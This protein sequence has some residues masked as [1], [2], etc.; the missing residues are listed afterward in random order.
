MLPFDRSNGTVTRICRMTVPAGGFALPWYG[1]STSQLSPCGVSPMLAVVSCHPGRLEG[2][3]AGLGV[4]GVGLGAGGAGAGSFPAP[5]QAPSA[6]EKVSARV[7]SLRRFA[8]L[9]RSILCTCRSRTSSDPVA[10]ISGVDADAI[11][12]HRSSRVCVSVAAMVSSERGLRTSSKTAGYAEPQV[13]AAPS[14]PAC[15]A[16]LSAM[17]A[18]AITQRSRK[19]SFPTKSLVSIWCASTTWS[20]AKVWAM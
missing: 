19:A 16:R 14:I 18:R 1:G 17:P 4:G 9:C 20:S 8:R 12:C 2:I 6:C 15:A 11:G 3:G 10:C 13:R 5:P 7:T